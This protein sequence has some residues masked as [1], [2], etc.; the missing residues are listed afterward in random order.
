MI[1]RLRS[2]ESIKKR[3]DLMQKS[4]KV[5]LDHGVGAYKFDHYDYEEPSFENGYESKLV[6]YYEDFD[7]DKTVREYMTVSEGNLR[8]PTDQDCMTW[9]VDCYWDKAYPT[10]LY[11]REY[12]VY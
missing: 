11:M 8:K 4:G 3:L 12:Q 2:P 7:M 5:I 1:R 9:L 10:L 6:I